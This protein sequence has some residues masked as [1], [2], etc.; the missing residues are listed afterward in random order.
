[1]MQ[2]IKYIYMFNANLKY[3]WLGVVCIVHVWG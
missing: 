1:M 3:A 2:L